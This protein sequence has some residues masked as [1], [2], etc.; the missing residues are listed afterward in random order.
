MCFCWFDYYFHGVLDAYSSISDGYRYYGVKPK[1]TWL[2]LIPRLAMRIQHRRHTHFDPY[3]AIYCN[4]KITNETF[5]QKIYTLSL[6]VLKTEGFLFV[7]VAVVVLFCLFANLVW[8]FNNGNVCC[9]W[10]RSMCFYGLSIQEY[11]NDSCWQFIEQTN[12]NH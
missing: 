2:C 9:N 3:V 6:R 4:R 8:T 7:V 10:L 12:A 11:Q 1:I 5:L